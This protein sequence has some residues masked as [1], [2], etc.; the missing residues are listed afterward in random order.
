MRE[1]VFPAF[2]L[3]LYGTGGLSFFMG[4]TS[5]PADRSTLA[6]WIRMLGRRMKENLSLWPS[7]AA[8]LEKR[9]RQTQGKKLEPE[10]YNSGLLL[11]NL[12]LTRKEAAFSADYLY[13]KLME[14]S[15]KLRPVY[16]EMLSLYRAGKDRDAFR[17][18]AERCPTRAGRNFSLVLEKV[19]TIRPDELVDQMEVFQEMIRQQKMTEDIRRVQRN[20]LITTVMAT[21]AVFL[22]VIDF[23]VVV[24][25]MHTMTILEFVF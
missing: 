12:A 4:R 9:H 18:V 2:C 19:G 7:A 24:V 11:K 13:E 20:S 6:G 15:E 17:L 5:E 21:A 3:L 14:H 8:A 23:A 22:L 16:A 25:F 1:A 10:I